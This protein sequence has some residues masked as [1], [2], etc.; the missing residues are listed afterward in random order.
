M[1]YLRSNFGSDNA[2][3]LYPSI[4]WV[5]ATVEIMMKLGIV[6]ILQLNNQKTRTDF[7]ILFDGVFLL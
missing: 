4:D 7:P 2:W 5:L 6:M 1:K 3:L